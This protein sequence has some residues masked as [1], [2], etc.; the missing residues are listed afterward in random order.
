MH[1]RLV[2]FPCLIFASTIALLPAMAEPRDLLLD[3]F[4]NADGTAAFG[5]EWRGFTDRVMGGVSDLSTEYVDTQ[6][7]HALR[8]SGSVRLENN[9]GFIQVRLP[10]DRHGA[11]FDASGYG[12]IAVTVRGQPGSYYL[13][14]R[15][16]DSRRP[17]Q[18]YAAP[19]EV[20]EAFQRRVVPFAAFKGKSLRAPLDPSQLVSVAV[21]AYG[22]RFEAL[23]EIARIELVADALPATDR[24]RQ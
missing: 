22:E 15:T 21:V 4:A 16:R 1:A 5:T 6:R 24:R 14:L 19:V 20:T 7:G 23:I 13:H 2:R 8:M 9:G 10:L 3:D 17:W 12:G 11:G 18:Y